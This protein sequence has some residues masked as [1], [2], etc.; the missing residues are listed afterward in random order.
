MKKR[1]ILK[2][3]AQSPIQNP[4]AKYASHFN[5]AK[6]FTDKSKYR[7]KA[8]HVKQEAFTIYPSRSIVNASCLGYSN[9]TYGLSIKLLWRGTSPTAFPACIKPYS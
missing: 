4:V 7:R 8:K 3:I 1:R 6:I 5:K 2:E 9:S